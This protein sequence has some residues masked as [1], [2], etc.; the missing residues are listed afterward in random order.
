MSS[1]E[2]QTLAGKDGLLETTARNL[3]RLMGRHNM[4]ALAV[5]NATGLGVATINSL[6]RGVGNPTLSTL[7]ALAKYFGV[8]LSELSEHDL[9]SE[10]AGQQKA[11]AIP[12]IKMNELDGFLADHYFHYDLFTTELSGSGSYFSIKINNNSLSPQFQIGSVCV[13]SQND[14]PADGDIVL[15]KINNH[16]PCFRKIYIEQDN[17]VFTSAIPFQE[18]PPS[19]Y[20]EFQI[21]GVVIKIIN[22]R[23][24]S[25]K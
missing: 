4:D 2:A 15:V 1:E 17:F 10:D 23:I 6:R 20:T 11:R 5:S 13:I 18:V 25:D 21:I 14:A 12:L 19:I 24:L 7:M 3:A 22:I 8:S 9:L 16:S